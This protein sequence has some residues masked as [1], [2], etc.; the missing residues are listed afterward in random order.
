MSMVQ[1]RIFSSAR[2]RQNK[3]LVYAAERAIIKQIYL[4]M[5]PL[6]VFVSLM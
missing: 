5:H 3:Q 2:I 1:I 4:N 6:K